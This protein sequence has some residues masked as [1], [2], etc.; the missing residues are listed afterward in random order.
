MRSVNVIDVKSYDIDEDLTET[1]ETESETDNYPFD[2]IE[3]DVNDPSDYME[4]E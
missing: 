4:R 1:E 3:L 2:I